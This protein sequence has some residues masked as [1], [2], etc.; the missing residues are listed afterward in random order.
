MICFFTN[1]PSFIKPAASSG[2]HGYSRLPCE[3][4][5]GELMNLH[6]RLWLL[7]VESTAH[8]NTRLMLLSSNIQ[9]LIHSSAH[10][11]HPSFLSLFSLIQTKNI[12]DRIWCYDQTS[13]KS[14]FT[15]K[16]QDRGILCTKVAGLKWN[17]S[18]TRSVDYICVE[19]FK[20]S[21][22]NPHE[23]RFIVKC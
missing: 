7:S 12:T 10:N 13:L 18:V 15:V 4:D 9:L 22:I 21:F 8:E 23:M 14:T 19:F 16:T 2:I 5:E 17:L 20:F 11:I 1:R 6:D 3:R